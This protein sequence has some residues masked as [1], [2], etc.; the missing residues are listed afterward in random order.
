LWALKLHHIKYSLNVDQNVTF[1]KSV[2]VNEVCPAN[3]S[4]FQ[5]SLT[6]ETNYRT[7]RARGGSPSQKK[8]DSLTEQP[9][10]STVGLR[11]N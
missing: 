11:T 6:P 8:E 9:R 3:F 4:L 5:G 10:V 1:K 2:S 7:A